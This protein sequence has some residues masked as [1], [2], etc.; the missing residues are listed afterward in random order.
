[1]LRVAGLREHVSAKLA[2]GFGIR[3]AADVNRVAAAADGVVVG[4]AVV[5]EIAAAADLP[6]AVER[7]E[8]KVRELSGGLQKT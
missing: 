6:E 5:R 1:L 8:A 4:S 2:V 3:T 7:V